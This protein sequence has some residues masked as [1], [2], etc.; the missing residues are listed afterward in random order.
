MLPIESP[1][2]VVVFICFGFGVLDNSTRGKKAKTFCGVSSLII[3]FCFFFPCS[4]YCKTLPAWTMTKSRDPRSRGPASY[5]LPPRVTWTKCCWIDS[6]LF[7]IRFLLLCFFQIQ[8]WEAHTDY[9]RFL[10]VHPTQ[11]YVLSASDDMSIK[12]WD[13][14]RQWD[15]TQVKTPPPPPQYVIFV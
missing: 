10:E 3:A 13:W 5:N 2:Y 8:A 4:A 6:S 1:N 7:L 14:E 9:I 12:L 15:C 11:P